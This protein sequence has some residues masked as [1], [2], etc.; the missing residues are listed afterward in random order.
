MFL[1]SHFCISLTF[2]QCIIYYYY[3]YLIV[4][5]IFST[6]IHSANTQI[7]FFEKIW[8]GFLWW[9]LKGTSILASIAQ[10]IWLS[11]TILSLRSL[12]TLYCCQMQDPLFD[13]MTILWCFLLEFAYFAL[14]Y[15]WSWSL[16]CDPIMLCFVLTM[17]SVTCYYVV[18]CVRLLISLDIC[19]L[20]VMLFRLLWCLPLMIIASYLFFD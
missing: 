18:S 4:C 9:P 8:E 11:P 6:S 19:S 5:L 13:L 7:L 17:Q 12:I 3:Y 14:L 15:V 2:L 10:P 16:F 1:H 20:M